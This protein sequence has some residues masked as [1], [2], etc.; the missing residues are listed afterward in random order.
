MGYK[1][2]PRMLVVVF[3]QTSDTDHADASKLKTCFGLDDRDVVIMQNRNRGEIETWFK[4]L[5][6][7]AAAYDCFFFV[8]LADMVHPGGDPMLVQAYDKGLNLNSIMNQTSTMPQLIGKPKV[9]IIKA[10]YP[11]LKFKAGPSDKMKIP[12]DS[13]RL[14]IVSSLPEDLAKGN[15]DSSILIDAFC[16]AMKEGTDD[17]LTLTTRI[18]YHFNEGL[19]QGRKTEGASTP[20]PRTLP[21]ITSTLRKLLYFKV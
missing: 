7:K 14:I 18:N 17:F 20:E 3:H 2:R 1:M 9:F 10:D 21:L 12:T 5:P 4:D 13:D 15:T 16:S 8:F 11:P 19:F 6:N